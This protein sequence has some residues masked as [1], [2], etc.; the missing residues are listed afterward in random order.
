M[1]RRLA[2]K[3][4]GSALY[5]DVMEITTDTFKLAA[6]ANGNPQAPKLALVLPGFLDTKDHPHMRSHVDYLAGKGFYAV[7][8]DPPG[9]WGSLGEIN[10]YTMTNWLEAIQ[11]VIAHFGSRPTFT[12]G[13]SRGGCMAM[14][15][16]VRNPQVTAFA[17]VMSKASY[18]QGASSAHPI[19][20]WKRDGY[21]EY[22]VTIPGYPGHKKDFKVPYSAVLDS[23][24]YDLIKPLSKLIKPKLF[25]LG[26]QDTV[27]SPE[28][29][30][31]GFDASAEP[32]VL[33]SVDSEH[34]YRRYPEIVEQVNAH[35]G[36]FL[37]QFGL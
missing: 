14:L 19:D 29:V 4:V 18:G 11:E 35:V 32:K 16:T 31:E 3:Q 25:I 30:R 22:H 24:K 34:I 12:M 1:S 5:W 37:L 17:A 21:R 33:R 10:T 27:V 28:T 13:T 20:E 26:L 9:T 23:Q 36:Q 7:S 2:H 15:A 6:Y 8:F